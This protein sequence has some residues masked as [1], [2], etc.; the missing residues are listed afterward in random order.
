MGKR[1]RKF[2]FSAT[3]E[4]TQAAECLVRIADGL[5]RGVVRLSAGGETLQLTP[6]AMLAV[7]IQAEGKRDKAAGHLAVELSW[8]PEYAAAAET[9]EITV[10]PREMEDRHVRA[11]TRD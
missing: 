7:E 10:D 2:A 3:L 1:T 5:R 8:T 4:A 6:T 11:G 9:L